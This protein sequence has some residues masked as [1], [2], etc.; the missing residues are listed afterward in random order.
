MSKLLVANWKMQLLTGEAETL[1][2]L[3]V[4]ER[5]A[6]EVVLCP[7]FPALD[8]I[9]RVIKRS[10]I[11]LGGQDL[12]W[13]KRGPFTG[14]VSADQLKE[15]GCK[16]VLVGHSE[17]R[18][19]GEI[20][21]LVNKKLVAAFSG[22]LLPIL[23]VGEKNAKNASV[24]VKRQLRGAINGLRLRHREHFVVAYE[25]VWAIGQHPAR[26]ANVVKMHLF[27]RY[28]IKRG[29]PDIKLSQ[30]RVIYGG[31]LAASDAKNFLAA[32]EIDGLLVG[33]ASLT[34]RDFRPILR[35]RL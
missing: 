7:S 25:P 35:L 12:F 15:A 19:L 31:G 32:A 16:Y 14:Q 29:L 3:I 17:R 26:L 34:L 8:A 30:F 1:A 6:H 33:G 23:C 4:Q 24:E 28:L 18:K 9:G 10:K 27:I 11:K 22:G 20:N 21:A 2:R 13:E 5:S